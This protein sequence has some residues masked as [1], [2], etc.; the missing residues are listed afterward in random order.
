LKKS[1]KDEW[2]FT[3]LNLNQIWKE[4]GQYSRILRNPIQKIFNEQICFNG[5]VPFVLEWTLSTLQKSCS[6]KNIKIININNLI[7]IWMSIMWLVDSRIHNYFKVGIMLY[8]KEYLYLKLFY[9][10]ATFTLYVC[11]SEISL[12]IRLG[13]IFVRVREMIHF[14]PTTV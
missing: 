13:D 8:G 7:F 9:L 5:R 6:K 3:V 4:L 12:N 1:N 10:F 2:R 14:S 11:N